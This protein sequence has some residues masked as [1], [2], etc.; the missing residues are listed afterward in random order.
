M[1]R[2]QADH[3]F[4]LQIRAPRVYAASQLSDLSDA[5]PIATNPGTRNA[6]P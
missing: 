1:R 5:E 4:R 3:E 2:Q 6:T